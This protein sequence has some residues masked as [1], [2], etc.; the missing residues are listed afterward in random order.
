MNIT[1][2]QVLTPVA[3]V[4]YGAGYGAWEIGQKASHGLEVL[5]EG[6]DTTDFVQEAGE[7][8]AVTTSTVSSGPL[9]RGEKTVLNL[10]GKADQKSMLTIASMLANTNDA[11]SGVDAVDLDEMLV[12]DQLNLMGMVYDAGTEAN[13]ETKDTIPGPAS[14]TV[15]GEGYNAQRDDTRDEVRIHAGVISSD[16]GLEGSVLD[17]SHRFLNYGME[18]RITRKK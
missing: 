4:L 10:T 16:D 9:L 6:G 13:R 12:G 18:I 11:F 3:A 8:A 1:N 7:N 5:A 17:Q 15:R 2:H 14:G